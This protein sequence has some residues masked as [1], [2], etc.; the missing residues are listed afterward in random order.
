[1]GKMKWFKKGIALALLVSNAIFGTTVTTFA[2]DT[3]QTPQISKW[4]IQSLNEGEKYGIF[5][6][7]WYYDGFQE[8]VSQ[9]K[10]QSLLDATSKKINEVGL[11]TRDN[12]SAK[13]VT[14][15]MTQGNV[16]ALLYNSA[17]KY[18]L[19]KAIDAEGSEPEA[20][21]RKIG[22]LSSEDRKLELDKPC[23]V[24]QAVVYA[25]RLV[26][27][28]YDTVGAGSKG[29]LWKAAKGDNTIYILG[30]IHI[31][32]TNIYPLNKN[33]KDVFKK[34]EKLIVEA[35]L[36]NQQGLSDFMAQSV[37]SDGTT[38]KDH[39]S[40][41]TYEKVLKVAEK[42]HLPKEQYEKLKGWALSNNLT[43]I[44]GSGSASLEGG[45]EAAT[46]GI[47]MYFMTTSVVTGKPVEELEGLKAQAG[48]FEALS[49]E[50]Q[51]KSLNAVLDSIL[52]P[53]EDE[54]DKEKALIELWQKQ[55]AKGDFDGLT[56][57]YL[58]SLE[59]SNDEITKMLFGKRDEAMADKLAKMLDE[60]GSHTYFTVVG[61]GHL[62]VKNSVIDLLKSKGYNVERVKY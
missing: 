26:E 60:K 19:P 44:I 2:N 3:Q 22:I 28:V 14:A 42:Y 56:A 58:D 37:Y 30:S 59:K 17:L 11:K 10:L 54:K 43:T 18:E 51:E 6:I 12:S 50:T 38:L 48:F 46:L 47:D 1:M 32:N 35:S 57:S 25:V 15:D 52:N 27:K 36:F 34:S 5:P 41:E 16:I 49:K 53:K 13:K 24:E 7:E 9:Q 31:G 33:L 61:T 4:A 20:Y 23:T 39:V 8:P 45:A 62:I 21:F 55:W 40:K 29:L